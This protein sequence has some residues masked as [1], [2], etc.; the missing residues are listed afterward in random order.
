[1]ETREKMVLSD[2]LP[3]DNPEID[4]EHKK[5]F[6]IYNELVDLI[7][8]KKSREDFARILT[9]MT[10]YSL[11]HFKK[12]EKYMSL[13]SYPKINEHIAYHR[14]YIYTV[15][16]YNIDLLSENPPNPV[17]IIKFLKD[18]WL[19]HII[20]VDSMYENFKKENALN[21]KY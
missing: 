12:E 11:K 17:E 21:I 19:N 10:D 14:N 9:M 7:E 13:L 6:E 3:I 4:N 20:K 1:M 2:K 16:M 18:W 15:A 8:L 5:L